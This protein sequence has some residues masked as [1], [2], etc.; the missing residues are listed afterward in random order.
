[1]EPVSQYGG[2]ILPRGLTKRGVKTYTEI[3]FEKGG[4]SMRHALTIAGSDSSGGAGIQADLK[5]FAAFGVYGMSAITA[6][7]AQN[8]RGVK[9]VRAMDAGFVAEQIACVFEDIRVDAVKIGMLADAGIV[10]AVAAELRRH[11]GVPVVLDPVMVSTSGHTLLAADAAAALKSELLPLAD[12][13]TP[14]LP[15]AA[16]LTGKKAQTADDMRKA[17]ET[18]IRMGAK[19]AVVKGGHLPG[20]AAD[21]AFD[22]K[23]FRTFSVP[24]LD[25]PN[26]HG[27]GCTYSSAVAALMAEGHPFLEAAGGAKRYLTGAIAHAEPLGHGHGPVA[28]FY[29][30]TAAEKAVL[31]VRPCSG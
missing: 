22:G 16:V 4:F 9:A 28:H 18:L 7:T 8:T 15:E 13:I 24:R 2:G 19:A 14:N 20:D 10:R 29:A 21:I 26:T 3:D 23:T 6:V 31:E 30:G 17:A 27:T 12:V 1:M 11:P 25:T 5:T